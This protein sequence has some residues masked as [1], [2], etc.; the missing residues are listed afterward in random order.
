MHTF[1]DAEQRFANSPD[2]LRIVA[3][4]RHEFDLRNAYLGDR[5]PQWTDGHS[6]NVVRQ[7]CRDAARSAVTSAA[8][9]ASA[10]RHEPIMHAV[11][12]TARAMRKAHLSNAWRER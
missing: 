5:A 10:Q 1:T 9:L 12:D 11:R 2:G 7:A 8:A 6:A 4:A 3:K